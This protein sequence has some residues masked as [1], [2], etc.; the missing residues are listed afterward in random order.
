MFKGVFIIKW[1]RH[2]SISFQK[3]YLEL[4]ITNK[5]HPQQVGVFFYFAN[6]ISHDHNKTKTEATKNVLHLRELGVHSRFSTHLV[7]PAEI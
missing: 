1:K 7:W 3:L 5:I 4:L 2:G 6:K